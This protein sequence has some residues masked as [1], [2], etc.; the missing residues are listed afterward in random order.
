[1]NKIKIKK[2]DQVIVTAG[3]SKGT[4][5]SVLQVL[6]TSRKAIVEG[7]NTVK[8]HTKPSSENP[9][10]GIIEKQLPI[11]ISN[12]SLMTKDG[13]KTRVGYRI[14]DGKKVRISKKSNE[15]I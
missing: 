11:D 8:K 3:E 6:Y 1:M 15:I 9:K 5:G 4:K 7:V 13:N 12:L 10:G 14:D 2:G